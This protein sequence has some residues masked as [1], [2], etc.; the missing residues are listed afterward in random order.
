MPQLAALY[1]KYSDQG[2][3]IIGLECQGSSATE[4]QTLAKT[5]ACGYQMTTGGDLKGA[6]VAGI[7]HGFLFSADG[8]MAVDDPR[9]PVLENKIKELLKDAGAAWAGEGPYVKLAPLAA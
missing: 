6:A 8:K 1:K 7:P 5:K 9:G 2:L 3:H 4:I